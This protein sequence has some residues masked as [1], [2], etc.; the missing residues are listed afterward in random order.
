MKWKGKQLVSAIL[1]QRVVREFCNWLWKI[2][3]LL[4]DPGNP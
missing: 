4:K 3:D 2:W 1:V